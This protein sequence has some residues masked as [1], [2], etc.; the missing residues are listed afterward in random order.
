[1]GIDAVKTLGLGSP[2]AHDEKDRPLLSKAHP[3]YRIV[4]TDP[5]SFYSPIYKIFFTYASWCFA[6]WLV[7]RM[8][9]SGGNLVLVDLFGYIPAVTALLILVA[10]VCP[11]NVLYKRERDMFLQ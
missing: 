8:A 1:M 6:S 10:L 2:D 11:F 3:G 7:F 9:T 5:S 4:H